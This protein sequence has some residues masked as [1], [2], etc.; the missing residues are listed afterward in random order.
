MTLNTV[1]DFNWAAQLANALDIG[2][3]KY[4]PSV[5]TRIS[6]LTGTTTG[7]ADMI[8]T[9]TRTVTASGTDALDLVGSLTGPLGNTLTFVK[10]KAVFVKAAS[11]NTNA[12]RI[13][14]PASNGV[15]LFLAASDGIDVLPGGIFAWVGP[16]AGVTVT[17]STGDLLN[18]DNSSS[19]TS[20][21]YDVVL[22][23]T[24]A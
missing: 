5:A 23:G 2:S 1:I 10:L 19:G 8:F 4:E 14:R 11:G 16:G 12:V 9:D 18:I 24:S 20:V 7:K 17:A 21:T 22:I 15:P 6:M 3:A 13:N